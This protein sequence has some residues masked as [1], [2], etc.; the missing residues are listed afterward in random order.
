MW[1]RLLAA[2]RRY[3]PSLLPAAPDRA[4]ASPPPP[5]ACLLPGPSPGGHALPHGM[6]HAPHATC[7][8]PLPSFSFSKPDHCTSRALRGPPP[9]R[10]SPWHQHQWLQAQHNKPF[11]HFHKPINTM[12]C[13]PAALPARIRTRPRWRTSSTSCWPCCWA[14]PARGARDSTQ[15]KAVTAPAAAAS[16][17]RCSSSWASWC[18]RTGEPRGTS[19]R[20]AC[21]VGEGR[22]RPA[23][24]GACVVLVAA[25]ATTPVR[26]LAPLP[27]PMRPVGRLP[28]QATTL[29]TRQ[30][31]SK[32]PRTGAAAFVFL[33]GEGHQHASMR[34]LGSTW[35]GTLLLLCWPRHAMPCGVLPCRCSIAA[36]ACPWPN[37]RPSSRGGAA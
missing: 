2:A 20:P 5:L 10:N 28:G 16:R 6:T 21:R 31:C 17:S 34:T 27:L 12:P 3:E 26:G 14:A 33:G 36:V 15:A 9:R 29:A 8:Q 7:V 24:N 11:Y 35:L 4:Q 18:T 13:R 25:A 23:G 1:C 37:P 22:A 30:P 32:G 19:R